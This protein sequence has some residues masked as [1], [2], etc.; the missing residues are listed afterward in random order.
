MLASAASKHYT[1]RFGDHVNE[2][3]NGNN[4]MQEADVLEEGAL[5]GGQ[6]NDGKE[7]ATANYRIFVR[8]FHLAMMMKEME[9]TCI[10]VLCRLHLP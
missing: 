7:H 3:L 2:N 4:G 10:A 8:P 5:T 6:P 1:S 9:G